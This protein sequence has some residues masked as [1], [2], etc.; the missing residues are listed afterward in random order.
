MA[1][2]GQQAS[3]L[4]IECTSQLRREALGHLQPT[5]GRRRR[6]GVEPALVSHGALQPLALHTPDLMSSHACSLQSGGPRAEWRQGRTGPGRA[7]HRL[8]RHAATA[9]GPGPWWPAQQRRIPGLQHAWPRPEP[10]AWQR[11]R[12]RRAGLQSFAPA[13]ARRAR[14]FH[15][16]GRPRPLA[17][18]RARQPCSQRCQRRRGLCAGAWRRGRRPR[19]G[20]R[21]RG[22]GVGPRKG[23]RTAEGGW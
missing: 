11:R 7:P 17:L 9:T 8:R 10:W 1:G 21:R 20:P 22:G 15:A 13:Y 2:R 6:R 18:R 23:A 19:V 3:D 4:S 5:A 12:P 16:G 14:R